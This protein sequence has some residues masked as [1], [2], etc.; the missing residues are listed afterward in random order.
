M[1]DEENSSRKSGVWVGDKGDRVFQVE[2]RAF[3]KGPRCPR[4]QCVASSKGFQWSDYKGLGVR[5]GKAW[6][7]QWDKAKNK[8]WILESNQARSWNFIQMAMQS[9]SKQ[10]W[11]RS[12][13]RV[14]DLRMRKSETLAR[15]LDFINPHP[16]FAMNFQSINDGGTWVCLCRGGGE[17]E[18]KD[19]M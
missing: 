15:S 6:W 1:K 10:I 11:G 13:M 16:N 3:A 7:T 4:S 14:L 18:G 19:E 8:G 2:R 9:H 12:R 5:M 17:G